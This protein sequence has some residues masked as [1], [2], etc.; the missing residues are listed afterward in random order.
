M[1][2]ILLTFLF[3]SLLAILTTSNV[4]RFTQS[5]LG[6]FLFASSI[7]TSAYVER[8]REKAALGQLRAEKEDEYVTDETNKPPNG[9]RKPPLRYASGEKIA[10]TRIQPR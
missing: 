10:R 5:T 7:E 8:A 9:K 1:N 2:P 6:D 3:L 4:K